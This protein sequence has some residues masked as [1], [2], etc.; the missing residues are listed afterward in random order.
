MQETFQ[1]VSMQNE[2]ERSA[3]KKQ[4]SKTY[5]CCKQRMSI[6]VGNGVPYGP[7]MDAIPMETRREIWRAA[8]R[9]DTV[10]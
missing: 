2:N 8:R 4:N 10:R 3:S 6:S 9:R 5:G 7:L 1:I